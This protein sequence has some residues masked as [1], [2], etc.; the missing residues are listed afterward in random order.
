MG[1][2]NSLF[3]IHHRAVGARAKAMCVDTSSNSEEFKIM[4]DFKL[5]S[6]AFIPARNALLI[7]LFNLFYLISI[8]RTKNNSEATFDISQ[9]FFQRQIIE[10][11]ESLT[12]PMKS[13]MQ[14]VISAISA[15]IQLEETPIW[16]YEKASNNSFAELSAVEQQRFADFV[17]TYITKVSE[18]F[19][20]EAPKL[21]K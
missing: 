6:N 20:K 15:Y 5:D 7:M 4:N 14:C 13:N 9:G 16:L 18:F 12:E 11:Y 19:E 17:L 21:L 1:F 8:E 3:E 10:Y 2:I